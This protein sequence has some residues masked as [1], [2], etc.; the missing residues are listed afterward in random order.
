MIDCAAIFR[1]PRK[2][3]KPLEGISRSDESMVNTER[4]LYTLEGKLVKGE[5]KAP[6]ILNAYR[7]LH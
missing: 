4:N 3:A 6:T 7:G 1:N 5:R 2:K